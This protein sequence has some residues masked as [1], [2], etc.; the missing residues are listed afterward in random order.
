VLRAIVLHATVI[1]TSK[2]S[3]LAASPQKHP[4]KSYQDAGFGFVSLRYPRPVLLRAFRSTVHTRVSPRRPELSLYSL[5]SFIRSCPFALQGTCSR[6][7]SKD[8]GLVSRPAKGPWTWLAR[9]AGGAFSRKAQQQLCGYLCK[10]L[11]KKTKTE[12]RKHC[13]PPLPQRLLG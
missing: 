10:T 6:T 7:A 3:A 1:F 9:A 4:K 13:S 12:V 5:S 11:I 2:V 8:Q